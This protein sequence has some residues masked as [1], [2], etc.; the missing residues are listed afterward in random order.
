MDDSA[1]ELLLK[2]LLDKQNNLKQQRDAIQEQT[3]SE[4]PVQPEAGGSLQ[5]AE[6]EPQAEPQVSAEEGQVEEVKSIFPNTTVETVLYH[7][8]DSDNISELKAG[9]NGIFATAD[10]NWWQKKK[11]KY[12]VALDIKNPK[13]ISEPLNSDR[14]KEFFCQS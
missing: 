5:V 14:T 2:D 11:Y 9:P 6:G 12:K 13:I 1:K 7:D 4:V 3:T 10:K 8:S